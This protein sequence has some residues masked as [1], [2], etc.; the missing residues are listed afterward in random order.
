MERVAD[1]VWLV[2]G[3]VPRAMNVYLIEHE[4]G[5]TMFDAGISDMAKRLIKAAAPYGGIKRIVLGHGHTDHRGSA[6][7]IAERTGAPVYCHPDEVADA[8]GDGGLHYFRLN[9]LPLRPGRFLMPHL[10]KKTWD[11]GPVKI[12]DT[13]SE[14]DEVAGFHV[15]HLPGHAPGLI[16]LYRESDGLLLGSDVI[17]TIDPLTGLGGRPR[18]PLDGFNL[19][20]ELAKASAL[21]LASV[22]PK[23]IWAGHGKPL[24]GDV[25][26]VLGE[27]GR[28]GGVLAKH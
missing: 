24:T 15:I 3:G 20:T 23:T 7:E 25:A 19:D 1:G 14:G 28:R 17:Y 21:K 8:E 26:D 2:R 4:G 22:A 9:T 12:A 13:V 11:G 16:G 6:P 27:L 5:M 18:I 10:L